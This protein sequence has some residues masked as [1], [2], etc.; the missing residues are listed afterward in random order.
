MNFIVNVNAL[1]ELE[2][3]SY[4]KALKKDKRFLKKVKGALFILD[5]PFQDKKG[6]AIVLYRKEKEAKLAFKE[7]KKTGHP[8]AKLGAGFCQLVESKEG[9]E[10][11]VSL[12]LGN[13]APEKIKL[14]GKVLFKTVLQVQATFSLALEEENTEKEE[15]GLQQDT[16]TAP[17]PTTIEEF[18]AIFKVLQSKVTTYQQN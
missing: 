8:S 3:T 18:A 9:L 16:T 15:Q 1:K 13:L 5:Y 4:K 7:F 12:R 17:R 14:K 6:L 2:F 10:W 11:K